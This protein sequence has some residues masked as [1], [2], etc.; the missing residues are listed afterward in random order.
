MRNRNLRTAL[1]LVVG[2]CVLF[3]LAIDI[4]NRTAIA[5][6]GN[7]IMAQEY[8]PRQGIQVHRKADGRKGVVWRLQG[9]TLSGW[10]ERAEDILEGKVT[11]WESSG[12][13]WTVTTEGGE[14]MTEEQV[15]AEHDEAVAELQHAHPVTGECDS[16]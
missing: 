10:I 1:I 4:Q 12:V 9:E 3:M 13:E 15:C 7:G 2:V 8:K 6:I 5:N 14:D 11:C 16:P